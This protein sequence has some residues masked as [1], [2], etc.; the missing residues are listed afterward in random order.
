[1]TEELPVFQALWPSVSLAAAIGYATAS[2]VLPKT[3][4]TRTAT[5]ITAF[6]RSSF[7]LFD[8]TAAGSGAK[9]IDNTAR[10]RRYR[11][12]CQDDDNETNLAASRRN[13]AGAKQGGGK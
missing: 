13:F 4:N 10:A 11:P 5:T 12:G 7:P 2:E 3:E 9:L 8:L 1:M 6:E